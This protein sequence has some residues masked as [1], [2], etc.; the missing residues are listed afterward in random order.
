VKT[1]PGSLNIEVRVFKECAPELS[2][3]FTGLFN[4]CLECGQIPYELKIAQ[5]TPVYQGKGNKSLVDNYRPISI[6][7]P[8]SKDFES[9]MGKKLEI[10]FNKTRSF[11]QIKRLS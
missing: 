2:M 10:I 4:L 1:P 7:S 11:T 5:T 3:V 8:I 9:V 6:I